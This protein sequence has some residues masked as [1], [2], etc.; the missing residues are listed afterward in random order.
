MKISSLLLFV[1][2]FG[3]ITAPLSNLSAQETK[4]LIVCSTTQ[5][6]DFA[7]NIVGDD[8]VVKS[9]LP[10]GADPHTYEVRPGDARLVASADLCIENGWHLEGK[11]WMK[12]L[13]LDSGKKCV[14]AVTGI[15]PL[16]LVEEGTTVYDPHAWFTPKNG[17]TYV[18]NITNAIVD[19]DPAN[20]EKYESR[21]RLYL[22]QLRDLD[23]WIRQEVNNIPANKRILI[24]NHDAF[25]YFCQEYGFQSASP[26][27]WSTGD[28][29]GAGMSNA[30]RKEVI[31][32]IKAYN[33]K[34]I[35][36]ETSVNPKTMQEL[37]TEA[38]VK[39]GGSLYSDSM[40]APGSAGESYIG[41]MR[42]NVI[43]IVTS[44]K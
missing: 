17:A 20:Q 19:I 31:D 3:S 12:Q 27:G 39:V 18:R 11:D 15:E 35:F 36:M 32:S 16:K 23:T 1:L 9:I 21:A 25:G 8:M 22:I 44:L 6:A 5:T 42:E 40:G 37:A 26:V 29:I 34:A 14:T 43:K 33:V 2:S 30:K 24:T 7:R 38:G 4:K 41:M 10:E 13:C 28:E